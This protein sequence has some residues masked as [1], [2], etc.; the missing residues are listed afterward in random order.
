[1]I[2]PLIRNEWTSFIILC[3]NIFKDDKIPKHD[4][5]HGFKNFFKK[6]YKSNKNLQD[7]LNK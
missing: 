1:M 2:S 6:N 4:N 7:L 5:N 3:C